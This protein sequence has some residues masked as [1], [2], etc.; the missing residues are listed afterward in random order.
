MDGDSQ[1]GAIS[2]LG[3]VS[4]VTTGKRRAS[5]MLDGD[6]V[7]AASG[8]GGKPPKARTLGGDRPREPIG[9]VKELRSALSGVVIYGGDGGGGGGTALRL[10]VPALKTFL[11]VKS[12]EKDGDFFEARN[13]EDGSTS[14]LSS[15]HDGSVGPR[16]DVPLQ[17]HQKSLSRAP[18]KPNSWITLLH[19]RY[20]WL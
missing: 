1:M 17:N 13:Y 19:Q 16:A 15:S 10:N 7:G 8:L 20:P 5:E 11:S 14:F 9:P 3:D 18:S 6:D 4:A 12:E 2:V